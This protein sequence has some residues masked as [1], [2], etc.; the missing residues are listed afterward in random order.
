MPATAAKDRL[1]RARRE[2][3]A[4]PWLAALAVLAPV[5]ALARGGI[6]EIAIGGAAALVL[7]AMLATIER[8]TQA[9]AYA[10]ALAGMARR[11]EFEGDNRAVSLR[12]Q[13]E[14]AVDD[15]M[16]TRQ[17][18]AQAEELEHA[19][20]ARD[21]QLRR[22]LAEREEALRR[23]NQKLFEIAAVDVAELRAARDAA[24]ARGQESETRASRAVND[25]RRLE[26]Q[27]REAR[28]RVDELSM[29]LASVISAAGSATARRPEQRRVRGG[30][31]ER[32]AWAGW[33]LDDGIL[34]IEGIAE[35]ASLTAVRVRQVTGKV[36]ARVAAG[37]DPETGAIR[38]RLPEAA[39]RALRGES[40]SLDA[41]IDERW[42]DVP[43]RA[44]QPGVDRSPGR[45]K[46]LR[47]VAG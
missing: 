40:A 39:C 28:G 4:L 21:E 13:F 36:I 31:V 2:R 10:D 33:T 11:L 41:L 32:P 18:L 23:A 30:V 37:R 17:R 47:V 45:P 43:E 3:T 12:R 1:A 34:G 24:I 19:A 7:A 20:R 42:S 5:V 14:W 29:A 22:R 38:V 25:A 46:H 26:R 44:A 8:R 6:R 27:L 9:R 16:A 35:E 15:L